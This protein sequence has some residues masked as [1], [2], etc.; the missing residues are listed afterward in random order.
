MV[1]VGPG[2][3]KRMGRPRPHGRVVG[4]MTMSLDGF[5]C[6]RTGDLG[7]LYPD[8]PQLREREFVREAIRTTGAVLMGR[9]TYDLFPGD[10]SDYEFQVP[11]F[12]VTH[13]PP[14]K[15]HRGTNDR[16]TLT[17]VTDGVESAV[18]QAKVAARGKDVAVVGGP[19]VLQQLVERG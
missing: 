6:D 14:A 1:L 2:V 16:L 12:V 9:H 17:F 19:N 3:R 4:G 15:P 8:L 18:A 13:Q 10:V 5:V 7:P 11:L